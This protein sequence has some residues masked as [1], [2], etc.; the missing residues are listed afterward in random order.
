MFHHMNVGVWEAALGHGSQRNNRRQKDVF[1]QWHGMKA[2]SCRNADIF[3]S[4]GGEPFNSVYVDQ[5]SP[6]NQIVS[7]VI[8][9]NTSQY[10]VNTPKTDRNCKFKGTENVFGR[11]VNDVSPSNVCSMKARSNDIKGKFVQIEQRKSARH[12]LR[13]WTN[14]FKIAFPLN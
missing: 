13:M 1:V 9:I 7:A 2:S 4:A 8:R 14:A 6:V 12:D 3:M 11:L 5:N 10:R